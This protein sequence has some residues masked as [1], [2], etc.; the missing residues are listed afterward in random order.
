MYMYKSLLMQGE[1]WLGNKTERKQ[2]NLFRCKCSLTQFS[3]N[4]LMQDAKVQDVQ[5]GEN[6]S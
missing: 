2:E 1:T 4:I 5:K 6:E 3:D